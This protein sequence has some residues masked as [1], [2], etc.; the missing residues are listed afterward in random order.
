MNDT[1]QLEARLRNADPAAGIDR[2]TDGPTARRIYH[3]VRRHVDAGPA[4]RGLF[5]RVHRRPLAPARIRRRTLALAAIAAVAAVAL[6]VVPDLFSGTPA[7]AIR[8]LP[9][10][11]IVIDWSM[12]SFSPN[13]A[14]IAEDLR[15]YG[16][17]VEITTI[18][19]SPSAVGEVLAAYP[20]AGDTGPPRGLTIGKEG[21]PEA[22][23]WT[24]DPTVFR[25]PVTL[26][27]S[28][29]ASDGEPYQISQEVFEPGEVL[30]GLQCALGEPLRAADV[31]ARLPALGITAVWSVID[32]ASVTAD[33]Y[34]ET[35]VDH[36][37][38]GDILWGYALDDATVQF[39]VA[40]DGVPLSKY[41]PARL[42]DVP[43]TP[44]QAAPWK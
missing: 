14:A 21:T 6:A 7:Y 36:V 9:N 24:I 33:G 18:P 26:Q 39:T 22:F 41:P 17:E 28:V 20:G 42:S 19:V 5:R 27:V 34:H 44:E 11:V 32:P 37:P 23:T 15:G 4:V 40:P 29:P 16:V 2:G 12:D 38:D 8:Q 35:P 13:A 1:D 10:G 30:G 25:G 43:C 31:A 3:E